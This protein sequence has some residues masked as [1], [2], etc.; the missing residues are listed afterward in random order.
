MTTNHYIDPRWLAAPY[1]RL[2]FVSLTHNHFAL[3]MW[4]PVIHRDA[5]IE[6]YNSAGYFLV[7]DDLQRLRQT[8]NRKIRKPY[9]DCYRWWY[10]ILKCLYRPTEQ[11]VNANIKQFQTD[12]LI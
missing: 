7:R 11:L 9:I 8:K 3:A 1:E 2:C 5:E 10:L 12:P 6:F 4:R